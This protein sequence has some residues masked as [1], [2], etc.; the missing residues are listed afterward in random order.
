MASMTAGT[1][2]SYT[3]FL[4]RD[5]LYNIEK[6]Y[7]LRYT[8]P[9]GFPRANIKLDRHN[10]S[11]RDIRP[12]KDELS[13]DRNGCFVWSFQTRMT[14]NDFDDKT[15]ILDVYL[16]EVADRLRTELGAEKVQVFEHTVWP[17]TLQTSLCGRCS[18]LMEYRFASGTASFQSR[19]ESRMISISRPR[20][21]T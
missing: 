20:S 1:I 4:K 2:E 15:K 14:Y 7:T 9:N 3:H 18:V 11:V 12:Q 19:R 17:Q 21:R 6:P 8:A 5:P 13:L 16:S 10:L